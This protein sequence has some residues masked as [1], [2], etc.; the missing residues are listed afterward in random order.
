V[1]ETL[2]GHGQH[3]DAHEDRSREDHAAAL[4]GGEAGDRPG[5]DEHEDARD[6]DENVGDR[7]PPEVLID[8]VDERDIVIVPEVV[9]GPARGEE[10]RAGDEGDRAACPADP[11][12]E[13]RSSGRV[14]SGSVGDG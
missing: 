9:Q 12:D 11:V 1:G 7:P 13:R 8:L 3:T 2:D 5:A 10:Q 4:A 14:R 6:A